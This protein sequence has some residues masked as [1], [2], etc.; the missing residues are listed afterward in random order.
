MSSSPGAY[1]ES[2]LR[3][4]PDPV[5]STSRRPSGRESSSSSSGSSGRPARSSSSLGTLRSRCGPRPPRR[6]PRRRR[7][8]RPRPRSPPF[9]PLF[10]SRDPDCPAESLPALDEEVSYDRLSGSGPLFC[11]ASGDSGTSLPKFTDGAGER[12]WLT[13]DRREVIPGIGLRRSHGCPLSRPNGHAGADDT[14]ASAGT[15]RI[16]DETPGGSSPPSHALPH[17]RFRQA[18]AWRRRRRRIESLRTRIYARTM[19][20]TRMKRRSALDRE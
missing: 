12:R 18:S 3:T 19:E 6:R 14:C 1:P 16:L 9:C 10:W 4:N 11:S 7:R 2:R 17:S 15:Q 5:D 13:R 20:D 8:L